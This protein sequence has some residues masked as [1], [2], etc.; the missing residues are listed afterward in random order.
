[1]SNSILKSWI[2]IENFNGVCEKRHTTDILFLILLIGTWVAMTVVGVQATMTGNPYSLVYPHDDSGRIC[3]YDTKVADLSRLYTVT[4]YGLGICVDG[5][6]TVSA[7]LSSVDVNDYYC[8]DAVPTTV[9]NF[10]IFWI[11]LCIDD[12]CDDFRVDRII[13]RQ[14]V[15]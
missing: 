5:C 12:I 6:P 10:E 2:K 9:I 4:T 1:M 13:S 7:N 14:V 11:R 8:L 3:G 15:W